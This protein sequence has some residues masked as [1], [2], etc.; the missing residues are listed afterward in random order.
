DED[1]HQFRDRRDRQSCMSVVRRQDLTRPRVLD[2]VG[3]GVDARR[4]AVRG[5]CC[6][7]RDRSDADQ[8]SHRSRTF[9]PMKSDVELIF[10]FRR[11]SV[12]TDT[13]VLP[14]M[15]PNVSP[16]RTIQY[17][18]VGRCSVVVVAADEPL[19]VPP[20]TDGAVAETGADVPCSSPARTSTTA[21][22]T[23]SRN[24]AGA[25]YRRQSPCSCTT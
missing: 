23:A 3:R 16:A 24:A 7:E 18:L 5:R 10:G 11:C 14:A 4:R 19:V 20:P 6:D 12:A 2:E 25:T 17:R 9:S 8:T 21:I 15:T 22:V 13:P 1:R